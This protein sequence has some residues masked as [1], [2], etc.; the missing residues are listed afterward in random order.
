MSKIMISQRGSL[1]D[2]QL[3]ECE[4]GNVYQNE[5]QYIFMR[6]IHIASIYT[7]HQYSFRHIFQ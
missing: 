6:K 3:P 1:I 4:I 5:T 7:I 2:K